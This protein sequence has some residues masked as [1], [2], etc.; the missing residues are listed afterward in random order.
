MPTWDPED[1][2]QWNAMVHLLT[3][4]AIA[5]R[6]TTGDVDVKVW[7]D[8][9]QDGDWP[10]IDFAYRAVRLHR[11]EQPGKWLEP[12]HVTAILDRLRAEARRSYV[13]PTDRDMPQ[14]VLDD[15]VAYQRYMRDAAALHQ[16]SV[17][18]DFVVGHRRLAIAGAS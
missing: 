10:S 12:G 4:L 7:L 15:P 18:A 3:Y 17:L 5:D 9:A 13:P 16:A 1:D 11:R 14:H 6:R 2:D 8:A